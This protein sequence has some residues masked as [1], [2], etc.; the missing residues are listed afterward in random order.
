VVADD[1]VV[2]AFRVGGLDHGS[3]RVAFPDQVLSRHAH[4]PRAGND[5]RERR[6]PF[7]ANLVDPSVKQATR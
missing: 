3:S 2:R 7:A 5:P 4:L 1:D 6:F